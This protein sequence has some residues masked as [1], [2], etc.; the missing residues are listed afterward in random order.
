MHAG[1]KRFSV[2]PRAPSSFR[3]CVHERSA[4]PQQSSQ[5]DGI[6]S[7]TSSREACRPAVGNEVGRFHISLDMDSS[8]ASTSLIEGGERAMRQCVWVIFECA[9]YKRRRCFICGGRG[10][11]LSALP[12]RVS[13]VF[14]Q[15]RCSAG[16]RDAV[17][18]VPR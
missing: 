4:D 15:W 6:F 16:E 13:C 9:P 8:T 17:R 14:F 1:V 5:T 10:V 11:V 7:P 3:I 12:I 18:D 2:T